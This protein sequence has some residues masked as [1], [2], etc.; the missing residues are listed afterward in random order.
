MISVKIIR[1]VATRSVWI[2]ALMLV[3]F[4]SCINTEVLAAQR[5]KYLLGIFY[6]EGLENY[7]DGTIY[8]RYMIRQNPRDAQSHFVLGYCYFMLGEYGQAVPWLEQAYRMSPGNEQYQSYIRAVYGKLG[9][10]DQV[11]LR[12]RQLQRA[13]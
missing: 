5:A 8:A 1:K 6:N 11:S 12:M 13:N 2:Y 10:E 7:R 3:M 9:R 4:R